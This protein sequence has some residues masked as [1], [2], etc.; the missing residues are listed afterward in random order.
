MKV[1]EHKNKMIA[2]RKHTI[3]LFE[4]R[5]NRVA[6]SMHAPA[7]TSFHVRV[8]MLA[9]E[10]FIGGTQFEMLTFIHKNKMLRIENFMTEW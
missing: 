1:L 6:R 10:S 8:A 4:V 2:H 3:S 7:N 5:S 9:I